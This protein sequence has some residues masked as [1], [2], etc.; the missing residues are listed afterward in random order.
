MFNCVVE[1]V[2]LCAS[3]KCY[4]FFRFYFENFAVDIGNFIDPSQCHKCKL[5]LSS[6]RVMVVFAYFYASLS[7]YL[8]HPFFKMFANRSM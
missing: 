8:I 7:K 2:N 6:F 3:L 1:I 5:W 4:S